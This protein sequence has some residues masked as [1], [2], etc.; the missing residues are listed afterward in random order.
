MRLLV[1]RPEPDAGELKA[2]LIGMGHEV[3]I[4]PLLRVDYFELDPL[5]VDLAEAQALIATSR[6]GIRGLARSAQATSAAGL[7]VFAVGPGTASTARAL[8]FG[9]VIQGPADAVALAG[10]ISE[11]AEVNAGPLVYLTGEVM[12]ADIGS[13][14]R[15]LGFHVQ[16]PIVYSVEAAARFSPPIIDRFAAGEIDGVILMS[17]QTARTYVRLV[18]LHGLRGNAGGIMHFCL[19]A[20]VERGL[21]GLGAGAGRSRAVVAAQPNLKSLLA[22]IARGVINLP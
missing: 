3:L 4:E 6:N 7:P 9:R 10:L 13:D 16:E 17:P 22:E 12:A 2:Q 5:D 8:G 18:Q 20:N 15:R 19:S 11:Q 21:A 1:T 14:L